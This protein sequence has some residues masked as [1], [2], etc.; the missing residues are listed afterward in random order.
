MIGSSCARCK[1]NYTVDVSQWM[2]VSGCE[3]SVFCGVPWKL[4]SRGMELM[5]SVDVVAESRHNPGCVVCLRPPLVEHSCCETPRNMQC[6][7]MQ[8]NV[9]MCF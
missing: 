7:N 1:S 5:Q 6:S 4:C 2:L 9:Q 3:F 8:R